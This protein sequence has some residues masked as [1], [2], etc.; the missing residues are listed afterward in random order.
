METLFYIGIF[1]AI[2]FAAFVTYYIYLSDIFEKKTESHNY[3][4]SLAKT[5]LRVRL[6][7]YCY[8]R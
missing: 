1:L 4:Y 7:I 5:N 3:L 6:Y 8:Q 2:Y